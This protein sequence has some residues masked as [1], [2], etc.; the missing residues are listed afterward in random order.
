MS[1]GGTVEEARTFN[2]SGGMMLEV[3]NIYENAL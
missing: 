1:E 3:M 2:P